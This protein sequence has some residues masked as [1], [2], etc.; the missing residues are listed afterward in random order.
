MPLPPFRKGQF[1]YHASSPLTPQHG[2][3]CGVIAILHNRSL[4]EEP[5]KPPP[6]PPEPGPAQGRPVTLPK[7]RPPVY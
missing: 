2:V 5:P 7:A 4:V 6:P 1:G 3:E